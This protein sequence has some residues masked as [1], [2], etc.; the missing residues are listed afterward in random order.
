MR[1]MVLKG[2][3]EL[4][5]EKR[6]KPLCGDRDI[7]VRIKACGIGDVDLEL[8]RN[9]QGR[10][11]YPRVLGH[12][13]AGVIVEKGKKVNVYKVGQKV[14]I[15]PGLGCG[16]C[17][18]CKKGL[19]HLCSNNVRLG[20]NY[21]GGFQEYLLVSQEEICRR[22]INIINHTELNYDEIALIQPLAYCVNMQDLLN[23]KRDESLAIVGAGRIGFLNFLLAKSF[24]VKKIYLIDDN[25]DQ[26]QM[27]R[28]L[29]ID[30]AFEDADRALA[31]LE[32]ET[33]QNGFDVVIVGRRKAELINVGVQVVKTKGRLGTFDGLPAV[34]KVDYDFSPLDHKEV[35][36]Y[37]AIGCGQSHTRKAQSLLEA[38]KLSVDE[39]IT[40]RFN[41]ENA[42]QGFL[43]LEKDIGIA[44]VVQL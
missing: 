43:N 2:P 12:E 16:K 5:L 19:E 39:I 34:S 42:H 9:G 7:L 32:R 20:L 33:D 8:M 24:G 38:E 41:L 11:K 15:H 27:A 18:Y 29:G 3:G 21:D 36:K 30:G 25:Q 23:I 13:I 1:A 10:L 6:D 31:Q 4:V 40:H 17:H 26:L 35:Q 44:A 22:R 28:K 37:N 14:F